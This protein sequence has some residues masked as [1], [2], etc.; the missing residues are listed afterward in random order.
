MQSCHSRI[1]LSMILLGLSLTTGCRESGSETAGE[2]VLA[3][4]PGVDP[5]AIVVLGYLDHR[6]GLIATTKWP[7]VAFAIGDGTLLLTSAH[8]VADFH[9]SAGQAL[10]M[11]IV[12][13]SSYYGDVFDFNIVAIDKQADVAI[14]RA[15]W[16]SHPALTLAAEQELLGAKRILVAG[17]P[18][19]GVVSADLRTELLPVSG[20]NEAV[21]SCAVRLKGARLIA[22]GWSGSALLIPKT[23]EVGGVLNQLHKGSVRRAFFFRSTQL[24]AMGCSVRPIYSLLRKHGLEA[25]ALGR[26]ANL[27][28]IAD[29]EPAFSAAIRY[30]Q[31]LFEKDRGKLVDSAA[32]LTRLRPHS[33]QAHLLAGIA[34]LALP[35]GSGAPNEEQF[36]HV[37]SSY[38]RA[39]EIDPN[40]AYARATY[41]N[42]L[43]VRGR[44]GQAR[45]QSDAAL[46]IDPNNHLALFNR[47]ILSPPVQRRDAAE[48][49]IAIEPNDPL[50]WFHY[51]GALLH[52][53]QT[54]EALR[55]AQRA[56]DL[57]PNG[58]F[59]GGLGDALTK[60]GRVDEAEPCYRRMTERCGCDRCWYQYAAFLAEHCQD[61]PEEALQALRTAESKSRSDKVSRKSMEALRRRLLQKRSSDKAETPISQ[62]PQPDPNYVVSP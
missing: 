25:A 9:A 11:D 24:N 56:V 14:L 19:A 30:V 34:A 29:S 47:L 28:P 8:C 36:D 46:A 10:S 38:K 62:V 3:N 37:E 57:D 60:L 2:R 61:R 18:Q 48:R 51:S 33:V 27:E 1:M 31:A 54:E 15:P 5:R 7:R 52:L 12:V 26:P 35:D 4:L 20:I 59:Y 32:E 49:L 58:L 22:R 39:L 53:G 16:P 43:V 40:H 55:A 41:G 42:F 21:P 17:R 44:N 23:G 6:Q 45:I 50:C 13:I